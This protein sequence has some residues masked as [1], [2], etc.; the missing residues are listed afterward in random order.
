MQA[1]HL[2]CA[3][4]RTSSSTAA[5][6]AAQAANRPPMPAAATSSSGA[7]AMAGER[8]LPKYVPGI[9]GFSRGR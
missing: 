4:S 9:A 7:V 5:A 3:P 8:Q 2:S 1:S 6:T